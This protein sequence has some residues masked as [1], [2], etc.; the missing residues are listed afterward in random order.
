MTVQRRR[1]W[2]GLENRSRQ[3]VDRCSEVGNGTELFARKIRVTGRTARKILRPVFWPRSRFLDRQLRRSQPLRT[4]ALI[5]TAIA[6]LAAC[7]GTHPTSRTPA[8]N[9]PAKGGDLIVS[10]RTEPRSFCT[11]VSPD[12]TTHVVT[13]LTQAKLIRVDPA[14]EDI[15]PWLAD[16]WTRSVDG[17]RYV[18]KLRANVRFSDGAPLTADDVAFSL[19][20]AYDPA[21]T[22]SDSLHVLGK[23]LQATVVDA[24]TVEITF[25]SPFGPGLRVLDDLRILPR[26]KL[27]GALKSGKFAS[28]WSVATPVTDIVGLGPFVIADYR[29]GE[30]MVFSRNP[31][32]FRSDDRGVQLPYLDRIVVEIVPEQDAQVLKLEAGQ[33]DTEASEIRP[34]DYAPLKR[35]A[36]QG[37]MRLL[38]LGLAVDPDAFWINLRPGAFDHDPRREW[39]QRDELRAAISFAVDRQSFADT[40]F[41]GAATPVFGPIT[42]SNRKWFSEEVPRPGHD[43]SRAKQLLA[44]IGLVDRNSDGLVEDVTGRPARLTLLTAKG[45][46]ALERGALVIRDELLKI[47][48]GVDVVRLDGNALVQKFVSGQ[49]YDAVLFHLTSTATDPALNADYWLSSGGA[50]I[51]NPGQKAPS[52]DWERQIDELMARNASALDDASRKT[53]FVEAQK[54]FAAHQPMVYFAAPRVF[55]AASTRMINLTPAISRPQLLWSADTIAVRH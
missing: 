41:L 12:A 32:Y 51:W 34:E 5:A 1:N 47:G 39:I 26:H 46:T 30:R 13:L 8:E 53:A 14:T 20:A 33:T 25:P 3:E 2:S 19:A 18:I 23:R 6:G 4:V 10:V 55:V 38:D 24:L 49:E 11:C 36:D 35:A 15:E 28:E 50:H 52:T 54:I 45:Q 16:S 31:Y 21:S 29:P 9:G 27:E 40:V 37:S 43:L 44:Q 48:L 22:I 42:P 17:L 7:D